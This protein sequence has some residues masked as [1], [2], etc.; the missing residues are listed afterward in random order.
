MPCNSGCQYR[1]SGVTDDPLGDTA[2]QVSHESAAP[3]RSHY[4]HFHVFFGRSLHDPF[5]WISFLEAIF[6]VKC[7]VGRRQIVQPSVK[8]LRRGFG[9]STLR[10][11]EGG[12]PRFFYM[13]YDERCS[14]CFREQFRLP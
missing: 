7:L 1:A 5:G 9:R 4:D 2:Q 14:E 6:D 12:Q 3:V 11:A 10:L 13:Q 8:C